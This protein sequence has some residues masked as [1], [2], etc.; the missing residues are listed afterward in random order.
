[1]SI[2]LPAILRGTGSAVI[3][4]ASTMGRSISGPAN[5]SVQMAHVCFTD[6][7]TWAP[8]KYALQYQAGTEYALQYQAR[9]EYALQCQAG[10][11]YALQYQAAATVMKKSAPTLPFSSKNPDYL[12]AICE[13]MQNR[14]PIPLTVRAY[15]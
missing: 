3:T 12:L 7:I 10:T 2:T 6:Y 8:A 14:H 9:T 11:E 4:N 13:C 15:L 5:T 1:M